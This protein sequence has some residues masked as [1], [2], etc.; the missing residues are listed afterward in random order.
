MLVGPLSWYSLPSCIP[1][2]GEAPTMEKAVERGL[3]RA[4]LP[5]I[6]AVAR[7]LCRD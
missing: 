3:D 6:A 1:L 7:V 4:G 5:V 2:R